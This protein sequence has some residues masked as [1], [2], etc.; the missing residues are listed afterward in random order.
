MNAPRHEEATWQRL[1]LTAAL[2]GEV[3]AMTVARYAGV[4]VGVA[5][6]AIEAAVAAGILVDGELDQGFIASTSAELGPE[7]IA[8]VHAYIAR[9]LMSY[10]SERLLEAIGHARA[11]GHL[12]HLEDLTES[13]ERAARVSLSVADYASARQLLEFAEDV[14]HSDPPATRSRRLFDLGVAFDGLGLLDRARAAFAL[15]FELAESIGDPMLATG[16]AVGCALPADFRAGDLRAS[17]VLQRAMALGPGPEA[18]VVLKAVRAMVEIRIPVDTE[19]SHQ[20]SWVTRA[21]I[22]QP[23]ADEALRESEGRWPPTRM[24]ALMGW[25][26]THRAPQFL[27]RRREASMAALDLA[28]ELRLPGRQ[29]DNAVYLAVDALES[30]DRPQYDNALSIMRWVAERDGNPYLLWQAHT[31]AAGAAHLDGDRE[32]AGRHRQM[33]RKIGEDVGLPGWY[34][35]ELVLSAQDALD[36]DDVEELVDRYRSPG[37]AEMAN[38]LAK[39][40]VGYALARLGDSAQAE[41]LLRRALHQ[42]DD[43]SSLLLVASRAARLAAL[44]DVPDAREQ[45]VEVLEPWAEHV[46]VHGHGWWADGPVALALARLAVAE[47]DMA[48][49]GR[50][51][52]QAEQIAHRILDVRAL[53]EMEDLRRHLPLAIPSDDTGACLTE[54]EQQIVR[55]IVAG[56]TNPAIASTLGY[57]L[58]TVRNEITVIYRKLGA[59]NRAEAAA[60]AL[61]RGLGSR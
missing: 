35:A 19:S 31:A 28:Q 6:Q 34:A 23:L 59:R 11:A 57:S 44:L 12:V 55:L 46:A 45:I 38:P 39:V 26:S 52:A 22:A 2:A 17:A 5:Q 18:T 51:I 9:H 14:G 1:V 60:I 3:S 49:A 29:V 53:S 32:R 47:G 7:Y 30:S 58:S 37:A 10:G 36:R 15:A 42:L 25:R 27:S 43:E 61:A 56:E 8:E 13:A 48:E 4:G 50:R 16:P 54:R 40:V 41:L 33:A 21:S 20:L 24:V